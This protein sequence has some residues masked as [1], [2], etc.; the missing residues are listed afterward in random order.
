MARV[1]GKP[2]QKGQSGNPKGRPAKSVEQSEVERFKTIID[3]EA[4]D[5]ILRKLC[6]LAIQGKP[7]AVQLVVNR[8]WPEA[9]IAQ[10]VA[11]A[12]SGI[13]VGE[14]LRDFLAQAA[15][16]TGGNLA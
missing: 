7:W 3:P 2:Y 9:F 1:I 15:K 4:R 14:V 13:G 6:A 5:A 11:G 10:Q 8:L 12:G 16:S